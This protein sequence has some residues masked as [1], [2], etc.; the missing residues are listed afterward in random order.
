MA[1]PIWPSTLPSPEYGLQISGQDNA[2]LRT[3]MEAGAQKM[4]RR[5]TRDVQN[6]RGSIYLTDAQMTTLDDFYRI[7]LKATLP[8]DWTDFVR[9]ATATYRFTKAPTFVR[10]AFNSVR[11]ELELEI[12]S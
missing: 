7:T 11:A 1:N 10:E 9:N 8:F 6:V 12:V 4:R 3:N 5:L 2:V